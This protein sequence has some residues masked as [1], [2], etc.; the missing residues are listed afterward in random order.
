M[1]PPR[2]LEHALCILHP[3][4]GQFPV[5]EHNGDFYSCDHYV[6]RSHYLGNLRDKT[7]LET[8][9][10]PE[11]KTFG[12]SKSATLPRRCRRC[13]V[14]E[15]CN[16]GCPKDRF[17]ITPEGEAGWNYL[18]V[19]LRRFFTH[20]RPYAKRFARSL[21]VGGTIESFMSELR[22]AD[23]GPRVTVGRNDPCPCGSGRKFKK[24]CLGK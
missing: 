8:L 6:D 17:M 11:Q 2:G 14:L 20:A 12:K 3:N 1:R 10:S 21:R 7:L 5:L 16:G 24:C 23:A 19:G 9:D 18:C 13:D 22:S 15:Y 4:C